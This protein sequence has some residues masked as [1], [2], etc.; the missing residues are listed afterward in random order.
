MTSSSWCSYLSIFQM[1]QVRFCQSCQSGFPQETF[2]CGPMK[3]VLLLWSFGGMVNSHIRDLV[4]RD[5]RQVRDVCWSHQLQTKG[6]KDKMFPSHWSGSDKLHFTATYIKIETLNHSYNL[7]LNW[8]INDFI[9]IL[10]ILWLDQYTVICIS[11]SSLLL[12]S[13]QTRWTSTSLE[14]LQPALPSF[15]PLALSTNTSVV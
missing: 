9:N 15:D 13:L 11:W 12:G 3:N 2:S 6:L 14:I 5:R 10:C 8:L 1:H 7:F 4:M